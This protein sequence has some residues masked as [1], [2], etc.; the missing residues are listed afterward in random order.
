MIGSSPGSTVRAGVIYGVAA[1]SW[2]GLVPIYFKA[3]VS[4]P[5]MQI[6]AHRIVWSV[7]L[8]AGLILV[9]NRWRAVVTAL[10]DRR[11]AA[12]LCGTAILIAANWLVF[13][14]AVA[15]DCVLQA[16]LGYFINPLVNVLLGF[17][18]LGE[19]LRRWQSFSVLLAMI[20]VTYLTVTYGEFPWIAFVL[21][22]SFGFYGLLRKTASADSV[23]GLAVET[24]LLAPLAV[25]YLCYLAV[26]GS[27][28]L[29]TVS[30][31]MDGLLLAAGVVT[32]V[33][34]VWFAKAAR[35]LR[36]AT[37]GFL[38]YIAPMGHFLLAVVLYDEPFTQS[39]LISFMCI[40]VALLV[41]SMDTARAARGQA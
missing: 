3:V 31:G 41:Y 1:Y 39:H 15:N 13:I 22:F 34:L 21:A 5:A 25:A 27:G 7:V 38:Q 18:F 32:A 14:W 17:V 20:G 8:L 12:T 6:L 9:Q 33:P 36:L 35:R 29:G 4:V 2:W 11:T 37:L 23:S 28:S 26:E 16:S 10:R 40:W 24:T 19:R 30:R